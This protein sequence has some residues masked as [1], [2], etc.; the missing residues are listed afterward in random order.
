VL[1]EESSHMPFVQQPALFLDTVETF[2][3]NVDA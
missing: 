3:N 1:S 2:L